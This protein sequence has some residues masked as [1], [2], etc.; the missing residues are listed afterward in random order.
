MKQ[1]PQCRKIY[2]DDAILCSY[3]GSPLLAATISPDVLADTLDCNEVTAQL[4]SP[5][6]AE[7]PL[8]EYPGGAAEF[9]VSKDDHTIVEYVVIKDLTITN[10]RPD[11]P[12]N[13]RMYVQIT[14]KPAKLMF[15]PENEQMPNWRDLAHLTDVPNSTQLTFPLTIPPNTSVG[16]HAIFLL[17]RNL[18][19]GIGGQKGA[20]DEWFIDVEEILSGE[21]RS[22]PINVVVRCRFVGG[23]EIIY[24]RKLS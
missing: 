16:G 21:R 2:D 4:E 19:H 11:R 13:I 15:S 10:R 9:T 12:V 1:C 7:F 24:A 17:S 23:S 3:D 6:Q 18:R 8:I 5:D 20:T 22:Y 14:R